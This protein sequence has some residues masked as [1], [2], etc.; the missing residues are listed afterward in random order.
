MYRLPQRVSHASNSRVFSH[1]F[2][3]APPFDWF[4]ACLPFTRFH[5]HLYRSPP[6]F[7]RALF[8]CFL[9]VCALE[10]MRLYQFYTV[11]E[12]VFVSE[13]APDTMAAQTLAAWPDGL[14]ATLS[15]PHAFNMPA[16]LSVN[17]P[18]PILL[19][20]PRWTSS[21]ANVVLSFMLRSAV[22]LHFVSPRGLAIVVTSEADIEANRGAREWK[23]PMGDVDRAALA[24]TET[25]VYLISVDDDGQWTTITDFLGDHRPR[26]Q[27]RTKHLCRI[28]MLVPLAT[29]LVGCDSERDGSVSCTSQ[30]IFMLARGMA[31]GA[32]ASAP[33]R[34]LFV[35]CFLASLHASATV[36]AF[37]EALQSAISVGLPLYLIFLFTHMLDLKRAL[38]LAMYAQT[39]PLVLN[40][41]FEGPLRPID[42]WLESLAAGAEGWEVD[43][44]DDDP[45]TEAMRWAHSGLGPGQASVLFWLLHFVL[46][47]CAA[48]ETLRARHG[49]VAAEAAA[50]AHRRAEA[51]A[52]LHAEAAATEAAAT[53][54]ATTATTAAAVATTAAAAAVAAAAQIEAQI[55]LTEAEAAAAEAASAEAAAQAT[56]Q[57]AAQAADAAAEAGTGVSAEAAASVASAYDPML[58][59]LEEAR[60]IE[61]LG[62]TQ[63]YLQ[64]REIAMRSATPPSTPP[65]DFRTAPS[66]APPPTPDV[67]VTAPL[68]PG[69]GATVTITS[70]QPRSVVQVN[71]SQYWQFV[72]APWYVRFGQP[73]QQRCWQ[74]QHQAMRLAWA[75]AA[76]LQQAHAQAFSYHVVDAR[77]GTWTTTDSAPQS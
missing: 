5:R 33:A 77:Q 71:A 53:A 52:I 62:E 56:A 15:R 18:L 16:R 25:S 48:R 47:L 54:T 51:R 30:H 61:R 66:A 7:A 63:R 76:A 23:P 12:K 2:A 69:D 75:Q 73:W 35:G 41:L 70:P 32:H 27:V 58:E 20:L 65:P 64:E 28:S 40:G 50:W 22:M 31:S 39:M 43:A 74:M 26:R 57:A 6:S 36:L 8:D 38:V 34:S 24:I 1:T 60:R 49:G 72:E 10:A 3:M 13:L 14:V 45:L 19:I 67:P 21:A 11:N 44:D 68:R 17:R 42:D 46:A 9:L 29:T 59:R 37:I 55:T 4:R